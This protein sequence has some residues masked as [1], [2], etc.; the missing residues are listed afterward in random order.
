MGGSVDV[1]GSTYGIPDNIIADNKELSW[2]LT[3][4]VHIARWKEILEVVGCAVAVAAL[5]AAAIV[6][7][8]DGV[9]DEP[10]LVPIF[11][12]IREAAI[13]ISELLTRIFTAMQPCLP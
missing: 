9:P 1:T 12:M 4:E 6:I 8:L 3:G 2:S 5:S 10:V 7:V 11:E 13:P